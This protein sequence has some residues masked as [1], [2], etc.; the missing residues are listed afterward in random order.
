MPFRHD[1]LPAAKE[2]EEVP[3]PHQP[4]PNLVRVPL[5]RLVVPVLPE[6]VRELET[7]TFV[8]RRNGRFSRDGR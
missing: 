3:C 1:A 4:D 2:R 5:G 7:L 6:Q 8:T